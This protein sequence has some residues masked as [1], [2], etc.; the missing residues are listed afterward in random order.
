MTYGMAYLSFDSSIFMKLMVQMWEALCARWLTVCGL[1]IV[2]CIYILRYDT[3]TDTPS[4]CFF[5][6]RSWC[7]RVA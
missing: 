6:E 1:Y 4:S 5:V 3:H 2:T 7:Y